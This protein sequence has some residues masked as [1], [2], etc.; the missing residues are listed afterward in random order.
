MVLQE[1]IGLKGRKPAGSKLH[2]QS[3][4]HASALTV[5]LFEEVLET[6]AE[7]DYKGAL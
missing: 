2:L 1:T 7:G 5:C 4:H 6:E 3:K